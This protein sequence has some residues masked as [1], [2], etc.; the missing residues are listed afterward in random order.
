[1]YPVTYEADYLRDRN[2]VTVFF[3]YLLAIPWFIVWFIY[4]IAAAVVTLIAWFALLFT[5]KYPEG[6]YR[7]NSG[8]LRFHTRVSA[9]ITLQ[10]D[11][12]PPFGFGEEPAYPVRVNIGPMERQ[13]RA[14]VFFRFIL[15]VPL[16]VLLYVGISALQSGAAGVA[17]FTIVFRGY[18]PKG[19][20]DALAFVNT[21]G[22]RVTAYALLYLTDAYPPVG[23]EGYTATA[24]AAPAA[25]APPAAPAA[26]APPLA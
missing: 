9:W 24:A 5:A 4:A 21:W 13:S 19:V 17:W 8:F 11:E 10:T 16:Y 3:R 18:Q 12:W 26:P 25:P 14:K 7:F 20:H 1:M 15:M 23:D 6:M 2:R 22:A